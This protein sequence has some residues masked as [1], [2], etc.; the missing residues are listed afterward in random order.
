MKSTGVSDLHGKTFETCSMHESNEKIT[1]YVSLVASSFALWPI[2]FL[3]E[4]D[5]KLL[6]NPCA[7]L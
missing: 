7:N 4:R 6:E 2:L 1:K 5:K 3:K